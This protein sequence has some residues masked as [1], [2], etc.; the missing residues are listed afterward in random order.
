MTNTLQ[1]VQIMQQNA[2]EERGEIARLSSFVGAIA[3]TDLVKTTLG[4]KGMDKILV[5][6]SNPNDIIVTNDGATI[7]TKIYIDNPAAKILVDISKTQDD[8][9]GDGTTSVCVLAGE[10]LRE[11]ER[12]IAQKVHPQTIIHGWRLALETARAELT[13][14]AKDN[15]ADKEKF[16]QDLINIAKTTLS[17]KILHSEKEHFANIVVD[18]IL[19]L[20]GSNNLDNIHIIKKS[21][22]SLRDSY[23][24]E[25][26]I[27]E[28]KIGVGCPKRLEN[29]KILIANTAM[30]TDKIKIFGGKGV[31]DSMAELQKIED[32]EKDKMLLKC[33]KIADHGI[34][35]FINR[36][37]IYNLPE[38]YFAEH[39]IMSIEH[40][41]F[42]GIERLALVTGAEIVSTFDHPEKVKIGTCKLIE[43]VIIGEDKVIKFTGVPRGEACTIV[44]RGATSHILEEAERSIH[45]ALCVLSVTVGESRTVLGGGCSEMLM[46]KAVD[47]LA[48]VTPGKKAIAIEAFAR[49]LRQIPTIIANNA[50]YDSSELVS[51]LKAAHYNGQSNAGLNMKD[52]CIG[53]VSDLGI[54]ESFK[55]KQQVLVSAH[56]AAEMIMRVDEIIRASPRPRERMPRH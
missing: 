3:I 34:N 49:A 15:S 25:G 21:G 26:F 7:L 44:L 40:A 29:A 6:A 27:L 19:R 4:P 54:L 46:A 28:K 48:K 23:L 38:Q 43:E 11:G 45:D 32:A 51:Q 1:P 31:V 47:E 13:K 18:A 30:D 20:K 53:N 5:S 33:K 22:G 56:E 2:S 52:G 36:Q 39:K 50:G 10:L 41:D 16:R 17:S 35:C 37:L 14:S 8:E 24:D 55:V 42:E 9:V 12:L